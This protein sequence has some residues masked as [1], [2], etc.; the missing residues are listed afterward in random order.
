MHTQARIRT[1]AFAATGLA[2]TLLLSACATPQQI[3]VRNYC[4]SEAY[5][6]CPERWVTQTEQQWMVTGQRVTGQERVC[7]TQKSEANN[8]VTTTC[9]MQDVVEDVWGWQDVSVDV[10]A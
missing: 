2:A 10:D 1:F 7:T 4:G 5:S 9:R 6:Q 8:S 3:A